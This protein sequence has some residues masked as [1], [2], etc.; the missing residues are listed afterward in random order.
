M[1]RYRTVVP[2]GSFDN[3]VN[4][5]Q[6]QIVE[7]T[8][9]NSNELEQF[10]TECERNADPVSPKSGEF[11][12]DAGDPIHELKKR[13]ICFKSD[14]SQVCYTVLADTPSQ[15]DDSGILYVALRQVL[16]DTPDLDEFISIRSLAL[17]TMNEYLKLDEKELIQVADCLRRLCIATN[18]PG[19]FDLA[20]GAHAA[21]CA[22]LSSSRH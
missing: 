16:L 17:R 9:D 18:V 19:E 13:F 8:F 11:V 2:C 6:Q 15:P 3:E 14:P 22:R 5:H 21:V 12:Y 7:R 20:K 4:S 10:L 1:E